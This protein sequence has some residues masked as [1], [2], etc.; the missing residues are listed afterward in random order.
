M[1]VNPGTSSPVDWAQLSPD[2]TVKLRHAYL[3]TFRGPHGDAPQTD[4]D[5]ADTAALKRPTGADAVL[6]ALLAAHY[7]LG[8]QRPV[9][10]T[11]VAVYAA[12]APGGFGPALQI[13]TDH[14]EMLMDSVTVLLHRLGVAYVSIM[15]PRFT[16]R[17]G[18]AGELLGHRPGRRRR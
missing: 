2:L 14:G 17:R 13:V 8:R 3:G 9:G 1:T 5:S 6:T 15:N 16:V 7:D 18:P 10:E 4:V 11:C 12:D